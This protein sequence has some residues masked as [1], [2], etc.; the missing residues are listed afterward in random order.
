MEALFK[1]L[2]TSRGLYAAFFDNYTLEQL[3]RVPPG[4]SNNLAWNIGHIIVAQQAL[5]YRGS[6]VPMH[7]SE[8]LFDRYKP[9]T[10]PAADL[11]QGEADELRVLLHSLALQTEQDY[12]AGRFSTYQE[13]TTA[14]GFHLASLQDALVFN[15][16][17]EGIH[18]GLMMAIRKFV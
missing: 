14:T 2:K 8:E 16:Y 7:I 17:H 11:T 9:G 10:K 15:N 18:L 1:A 5:V 3:N 4:F 13:R 6:G 12:E